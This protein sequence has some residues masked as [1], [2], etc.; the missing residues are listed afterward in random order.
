M[1]IYIYKHI[2]KYTTHCS[3]VSTTLVLKGATNVY[4]YKQLISYNYLLK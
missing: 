3:H 1:A 2:P 4:L